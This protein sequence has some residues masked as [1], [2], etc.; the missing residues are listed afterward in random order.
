MYE[1][2]T[3]LDLLLGFLM[4]KC[5]SDLDFEHLTPFGL[6]EMSTGATEDNC[7]AGGPAQQ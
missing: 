2:H 3:S 1:P 4:V 6:R 5:G 7:A